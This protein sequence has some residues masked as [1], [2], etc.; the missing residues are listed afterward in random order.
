MG[1]ISVSVGIIGHQHGGDYCQCGDHWTPAWG[2]LVSAWGSLD[3]SMGVISVSVGMYFTLV[4]V[5]VAG[6]S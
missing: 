2:L 5:P 1:I 6:T 3:T 4:M